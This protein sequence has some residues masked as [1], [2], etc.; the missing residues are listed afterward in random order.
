MFHEAKDCR[1]LIL[2]SLIIIG[3]NLWWLHLNQCPPWGDEPGHLNKT[4]E[5]FF[6][7]LDK[8]LDQIYQRLTRTELYPPL[9]HLITTLFYCLSKNSYS[10]AV[11]SLQIFIP[12]FVFS[13]FFTLKHYWNSEV[14]WAGVFLGATSPFYL[15][16]SRRYL[17]DMPLLAFTALGFCLLIKT[18]KFQNRKF[19]LWFGAIFGLAML[20]K[21]TIMFFLIPALL[22][23]SA[24]ILW[25]TLKKKSFIT[26]GVAFSLAAFI[27]LLRVLIKPGGQPPALFWPILIP[28]LFL[29]LAL[30]YFSVR[31]LR[32]NE[33]TSG[34]NLLE[35]AGLAMLLCLPWYLYNLPAILNMEHFLDRT[36][37]I[38]YRYNLRFYLQVLSSCFTLALPLVGIGILFSLFQNR[39]ALIFSF[40]FLI[41]MLIL[42]FNIQADR[43]LLPVI[44]FMIPLAVFWLRSI[45]PKSLY[46]M[47][48]ALIGS[49]QLCG[50]MFLP[51][52]PHKLLQAR[53]SNN[54]EPL[55]LL[56][57][58][59]PDRGDYSS[60]E[61]LSEDIENYT[62][63]YPRNQALIFWAMVC[64]KENS[65]TF[66]DTIIY[67][68]AKK[69]LSHPINIWMGVNFPERVPGELERMRKN[70]PP[71]ALIIYD[72]LPPC[73]QNPELVTGKPCSLLKIYS[74]GNQQSVSIYLVKNS[75]KKLWT[76]IKNT[77]NAQKN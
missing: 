14:A 76:D 61:A 24:P 40:S 65:I 22:W 36:F 35:A 47:I 27:A 29:L 72:K 74:W 33:L 46:L 77:P 58:K 19:S 44:F 15:E 41:A 64:S 31:K 63:R 54:I 8:N 73:P 23:Y 66:H 2:F 28:L 67:Y 30:I 71:N 20:E 26:M 49:V 5:Y 18:E 10:V 17:M 62:L 37:P 38:N 51:Q 1:R 11:I 34:A 48:F 16:L 50:W 7:L 25:Q 55:C 52:I 43:Y 13:L 45:M 53:S 70:F 39:K 9:V 57:A 59:V 68:L 3:V 6:P 60:I 75:A 69:R 42:V 32:A 12:I 56:T 21:W 4:L